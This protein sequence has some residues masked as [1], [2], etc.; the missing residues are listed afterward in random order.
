MA[1]PNDLLEQAHRLANQLLPSPT[2][3]NPG[4]GHGNLRSRRRRARIAGLVSSRMGKAIL[5]ALICAAGLLADGP[6]PERYHS[7]KVTKIDAHPAVPIYNYTLASN[8]IATSSEPVDVK[9]GSEIKYAI[10]G[11]VMY[12]IDDAGKTHQCRW[13]EFQPPPAPPPKKN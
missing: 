12:I 10:E 5:V 11:N 4:Y 9:E 1:F 7:V 3:H 6:P 2:S 13:L 8:Y